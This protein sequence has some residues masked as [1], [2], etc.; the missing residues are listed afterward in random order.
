[1]INNDA[2]ASAPS[3]IKK[4]TNNTNNGNAA[5][6]CASGNPVAANPVN[7]NTAVAF[8]GPETMNRVPLKNGAVIAP[9][10][11]LINPCTG[12]NPA[13]TE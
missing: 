12:G 6:R 4:P 11:E 3:T 8:V 1:M 5:S 10:P 13:I 9:M 7:N 2:F